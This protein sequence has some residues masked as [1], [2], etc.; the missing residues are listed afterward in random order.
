MK[1]G[2]WKKRIIAACEEA[3]TYQPFFE[4][5]IETLA[6]ILE[7][8]DQVAKQYKDAGS[9]AVITHVNKAGA[10]NYVKNP[11]LVMWADL[12]REALAY[13]RDLGLTPMGLK[14]IDAGAVKP[15][16]QNKHSFADV[17]ESIGV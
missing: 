6:Q 3:G 8:R 1:R 16:A 14:R 11:M 15:G 10:E 2:A 4:N 7:R 13:W 12:N 9:I 5:A 17:L